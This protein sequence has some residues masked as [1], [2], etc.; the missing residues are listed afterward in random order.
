MAQ[1]SSREAFAHIAAGGTLPSIGAAHA[2]MLDPSVFHGECQSA[3]RRIHVMVAF[4]LA[5]KHH[6]EFEGWLPSV[7]PSEWYLLITNANR[8]FFIVILT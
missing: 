1:Q 7:D 2:L 4:E 6:L 5:R 8:N 3:S